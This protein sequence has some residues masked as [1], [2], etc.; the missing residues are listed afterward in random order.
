MIILTCAIFLQASGEAV[1]EPPGPCRQP[2]LLSSG[3]ASRDRARELG[4]H[5]LHPF[6]RYEGA[7][8]RT[9]VPGQ[10]SPEYL[11]DRDASLAA[12]VPTTTNVRRQACSAFR[13]SS[14]ST[15]R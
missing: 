9:H 14:G 13:D 2:P 7:G 11:D 6:R 15:L 1:G 8:R 12:D 5:P 10:S 4:H 3:S